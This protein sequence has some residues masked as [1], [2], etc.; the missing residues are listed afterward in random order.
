ME[1]L[2]SIVRKINT[3]CGLASEGLVFCL[4]LMVTAEI[5]G[6]HVFGTPIPGQVEMA[7]LSLIVILYLG[8]SY[9]QMEGGHIRVDVLISRTKGRKRELLEAFAQFLC[10]IPAVMMLLATAKQA[11]ISVIGQEFVAGVVNFPVWPGRCAVTFGFAL[12]CFTLGVQI[13]NHV[14]AAFSMTRDHKE[15]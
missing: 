12:L 6:R 3:V 14:V 11:R 10:L 5:I 1:T 9:T 13:S 4:M 7:T 8:L 15:G 2:N